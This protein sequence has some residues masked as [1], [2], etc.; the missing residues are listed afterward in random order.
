MFTRTQTKLINGEK[1]QWT[2]PI[3]EKLMVKARA[4]ILHSIEEIGLNTDNNKYPERIIGG[5]KCTNNIGETTDSAE[6]TMISQY[7]VIW[8]HLHQ[9][10]N[11][12]GNYESAAIFPTPKWSL[13]SSQVVLQL[14]LLS[15]MLSL[16]QTWSPRLLLYPGQC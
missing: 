10:C 2:F 1:G 11:I 15:S 4:K 9:F 3:P 6:Q 13:P 5:D 14:F 8:Q 12:T 16:C 7:R